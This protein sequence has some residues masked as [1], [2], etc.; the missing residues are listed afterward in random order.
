[1]S[2][3]SFGF[4]AF[5][6]LT[7]ALYFIVPK[8]VQWVVLLAANTAFYLFSGPKYILFIVLTSLATFFSGIALDRINVSSAAAVKACSDSAEKKIIKAAALKKKKLIC[9]LA[10]ILGM[11]I[12]IVLK[13]GNMF[14]DTFNSAVA[15]FGGD[16]NV[17][18]MSIILPLG[19]SFYTFHA[20][21]YMVDVYRGKYSAEKNFFRYFTFVSFFPHIIQGP[22]SRYDGL[23]KS[24]FEQH[25]FSYDRL[26][27]G[28]ARILWGV[29]KKAVVAD[30]LGI[31]VNT[32]TDDYMSY[33]GTHLVFALLLYSFR[34]Y[35]D[36][37]GYMDIMCGICDILGISLDEN[38][39]QPF[40]ARSTEEFWRRWHIT[41]G[42]WFRDYV[43]YPISMSKTAQ[44]M[45]KSARKKW[46][47]KM[48]KL[49]PGYF[50][51]IFVWTATGMWHGSSW[52]Y[53]IWGWM[54]LFI[55]IF[56]THMEDVYKKT[57]AFL[58]IKDT[59]FAWILFSII[60][61][62]VLLSV[63]RVFAIA[64]SLP[65]AG[66]ML[67]YSVTRFSFSAFKQPL[68]LFAGMNNK[69]EILFAVIGV[70][71]MLTVDVLKETNKWEPVK[72]KC[73]MLL[74]NVVYT[75]LICMIFLVAGGNNDLIGGFMYANF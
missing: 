41:L 36:F 11:G 55:I 70:L 47:A 68:G 25:S 60:R 21:G 72:Q 6:V 74:R 69:L 54:S 45:G 59:N 2:I 13:Y 53:L 7:V 71:A 67:Y 43:F 5:C 17:S 28:C 56:S 64:N 26:C 12:W 73:P 46:G 65:M 18:T 57:K 62:Y 44:K 61:T 27:R 14:I 34:I 31:A 4:L 63:I 3:I 32:I 35:A 66:R 15:L 58:H 16:L 39:N 51:L 49:L 8:K 22:F 29:F 75:L 38:F 50:A 37:S 40:F 1:M 20:V 23:G 52:T 19:I 42:H 48:G 33:S 10:T 30:K 9:T 24:I